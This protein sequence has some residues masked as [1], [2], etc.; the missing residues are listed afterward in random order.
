MPTKPKATPMTHPEIIAILQP[1][2]ER[3]QH[4]DSHT[5]HLIT[6]FGMDTECDF[7]RRHTDLLCAYTREL[8]HRL[9]DQDGWLMWHL[10]DNDGC[11]LA[12][13]IKLP[14]WQ[15]PLKIRSLKHLARILQHQ[16][17]A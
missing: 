2:F 17:P 4:Y 3:Y 5:E 12:L 14:G 1:W 13:P 16:Q 10:W 11:K 15:K 7:C 6:F 9:G 8:E